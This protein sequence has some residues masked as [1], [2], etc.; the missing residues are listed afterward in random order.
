M[1]L[2]EIINLAKQLSTVDKLRLIRQLAADIKLELVDKPLPRKSLWGLC[3]PL[4]QAP[5]AI[6]IDAARAEEWANF[7]QQD[8]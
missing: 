6:E 3:A 7:P 8:L 5:S 2:Q 4:G 1:T